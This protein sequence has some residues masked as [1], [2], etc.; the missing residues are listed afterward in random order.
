MENET[1]T[2][3]KS[4]ISIENTEDPWI[5]NDLV[6][7]P[8]VNPGQQEN[9][10]KHCKVSLYYYK[11]NSEYYSDLILQTFPFYSDP[12]LQTFPFFFSCN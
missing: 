3:S 5:F 2:C 6:R 12:I 7:P 1:G 10:K 9:A 4:D 8:P 11:K